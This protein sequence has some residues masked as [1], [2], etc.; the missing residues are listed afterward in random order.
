MGF[1]GIPGGEIPKKPSRWKLDPTWMDTCAQFIWNPCFTSKPRKMFGDGWKLQVFVE[2]KQNLTEKILD[3]RFVWIG[4]F[5]KL[6]LKLDMIPDFVFL[7][8]IQVVSELVSLFRQPST[9]GVIIPSGD[10]VW[11]NIFSKSRVVDLAHE[12]V[13]PIFRSSLVPSVALFPKMYRGQI[14]NLEILRQKNNRNTNQIPSISIVIHRSNRGFNNSSVSIHLFL[15][16][17][18]NCFWILGTSSSRKI[19]TRTTLP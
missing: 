8:V 3:V 7:Q 9:V 17:K 19:Q 14:C 15:K 10:V 11:K 16:P 6:T 5:W 18:I 13:S 12:L 2:K 1:W 4:S